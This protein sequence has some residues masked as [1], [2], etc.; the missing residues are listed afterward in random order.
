MCF[1]F[2]DIKKYPDWATKIRAWWKEGLRRVILF[3]V[4]AIVLSTIVIVAVCTNFI[5]WDRF[6]RDMI[7]TNEVGRAFLASFIL[8]M[9]FTI[10]MQVSS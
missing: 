9:D 6:N 7:Y 5:N 3:W 2:Q 4:F 1:L 10:V 8:V